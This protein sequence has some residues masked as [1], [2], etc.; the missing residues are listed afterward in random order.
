[1]I[2]IETVPVLLCG[3][4]D[5]SVQVMHF[6]PNIISQFEE[7]GR[8]GSSGSGRRAG[9]AGNIRQGVVVNSTISPTVTKRNTITLTVLVMVVVRERLLIDNDCIAHNM[10]VYYSAVHDYCFD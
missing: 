1:M 2:F 3:C 10:H 5:Y 6:D 4:D 8:G 7:G 9:T